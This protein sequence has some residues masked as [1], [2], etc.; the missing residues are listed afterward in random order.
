MILFYQRFISPILQVL[1]PWQCK[2]TPSCSEYA[3]LSFR[4]DG[5]LKGVGK[6]FWR[7]LRCNPWGKGGVEMP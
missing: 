6:T 7:I 2:F 4:K 5:V 1:F 3:K